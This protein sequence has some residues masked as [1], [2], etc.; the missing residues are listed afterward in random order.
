MYMKKIFIVA[1]MA[2]SL[3]W[4]TVSMAAQISNLRTSSTP[5][6]VRL[7]L[8]SNEALEYK[9]SLTNNVLALS[10]PNSKAKNLKSQLKDSLV[11]EVEL[12][13]KGS[14]ALLT[15][16][17][18]K[19]CKYK[20]FRLQNPD[21][22]V[23]DLP[24]IVVLR[25]DKQLAKGVTYS[26][27][28]DDFQGRQIQAHL[29]TVEPEARFEWRPFST[30]ENRTGR[31]SLAA[32]AA[33][34]KLPVA[35]NASYF[36][37]DGWVIGTTKDRGQLMSMESTPHSAFAVI[38]GRSAV[39]KDV[40]YNAQARLSNGKVL[41]IK[42]MNRRR[43]AEDLVVY[44]QFFGPSTKTNHWGREVKVRLKDHLILAVSTLGDMSI[45]PGT[46]VLSGHGDMAAELAKCRMGDQVVYFEELN[47][48]EAK[49]AETLLGAGPLLLEEGIV[50]VRTQ[51]ENIAPD[52]A[53]GR[54]PRTAMGI[55]Q[56]GSTM[57]LVVD[58]RSET[59]AGM[60]LP[61]LA[62]YLKKQGAWEAVNFDG[63]GSSEMCL[64]GKI[65]NRPSDGR[66]R[67]VSVGLGLFPKR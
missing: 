59:S 56:D 16:K 65:V 20:I 44:N 50:N 37:T 13:S 41:E 9:E 39:L 34:L 27:I 43:I 54:A 11:Q 58:G 24:K 35:V 7:V 6:K 15:V 10:L 3:V 1:A 29:V 60:T 66:E 19:S 42:G 36:D 61:E 17:L 14:G 18:N 33:K 30:V 31:G 32:R 49:E 26:F 48:P 12:Q 64:A 2:V 51:E 62:R 40:S 5:S 63:G 21:R 25:Q 57:V 53:R 23:I 22:L 55:K 8:D 38:K 67:A 52:I 4:S 45:D 28:Q 47:L 46:I